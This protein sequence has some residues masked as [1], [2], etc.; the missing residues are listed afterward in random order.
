[1]TPD[2][3]DPGTPARRAR[4]L[5][6]GEIRAVWAVAVLI[7]ALGLLGFVNSFAA[8]SRAARPAFGG[9]APTVPL[10]T[11][12]AIAAFSAADIVLARLDIQARWVRLVPWA[13]TAA[14]I[15]LNVAGQHTWFGR[16]GHAVFPA[17][18]V[19]AV[20]LGAKVVRIRAQLGKGTRMDRI[21]ASRWLLAPVSTAALWRRMILWE[22][23]SYRG[24]LDRERRRILARTDLQDTYGAVAWRWTAPRRVRA[25]YRLGELAPASSAQD[26][27]RTDPG[28]VPALDPV[29]TGPARTRTDGRT[30]ETPGVRNGDV[31]D[32]EEAGPRTE[33]EAPST[34]TG[35]G[36]DGTA[37]AEL[38][39]SAIVERLAEE[40]R[41]AI[42]A[43]TVWKPDY[44]T[45]M[46]S[47]ERRRSWCEK[48]VRD[49]RNHVLDPGGQA[50]GEPRTDDTGRRLHSVGTDEA[51]PDAGDDPGETPLADA[52]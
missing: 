41:D 42:D 14:T 11:D 33:G 12:L 49:A 6:E 47:T 50:D 52:S 35:S 36:P 18:W 4:P 43:G 31:R 17:L 51:A 8:V 37:L 3:P 1:V 20:E 19:L 24:A 28:G 46:T 5:A 45:L 10:G 16:I 9:L 2:T 26:E 21:R 15:Y 38:P 29:R 40:I 22:I 13:L 39:R 34:D 25:L 32:E 7:G 30:D 27:T 23:T 48:V 44:D